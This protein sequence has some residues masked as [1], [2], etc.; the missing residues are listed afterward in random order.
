MGH[1]KIAFMKNDR[2][3]CLSKDRVWVAGRKNYFAMVFYAISLD[4]SRLPITGN[5]RNSSL[6]VA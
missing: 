1:R 5:R 6:T 4:A 2:K 3:Q